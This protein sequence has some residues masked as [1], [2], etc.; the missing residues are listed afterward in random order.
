MTEH[1]D[2]HI[3]K[4][5]TTILLVDDDP[6]ILDG[7]TDLLNIY[8]YQVIAVENGHRALEVM[9]STPPN[10]VIS[11]ISMP[12]MDGYALF[13]A[14]RSNPE[15]VPIPFIF[16]T[17]RGQLTDIRRGRRIGA[18]GYLTKPFDPEELLSAVQGQIKR[19]QDIRVATYTDVEAMKQRLIAVFSH[20]L[21]T[22]LT[23]IY[24]YVNLLRD[25]YPE[26]GQD[27]IDEMLNG[28]QA[29]AERLYRLV[30]DLML[31]VRIDSGVVEVEIALGQ[32]NLPL[33]KIIEDISYEFGHKAKQRNVTLAY[34]VPEELKRMPVSLYIRDALKRLIDNAIKF[35][36]QEGGSV[37]VT[38]SH[39]DGKL[40]IAVSDD[41][42]G[43][44]PVQQ[45]IIFE[46]FQQA[47][48]DTLEQQGLGL[49]LTLARALV[50]LHS[51]EIALESQTGIGSTF[52]LI[53]PTDRMNSLQ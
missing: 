36:K 24:G 19:T 9:Q 26:L 20:E 17:A 22:P 49:G 29:G 43:I 31:M 51:G 27:A 8:G 50:R 3:A 14:V 38:L 11:D 30:E 41:G 33:G 7:V 42:I 47:N 4:M 32:V 18:D 16:L 15:W 35:S 37:D 6:A 2:D 48:R 40:T 46:S 25:Q 39:A 1:G 34:H 5:N 45:D 28:I 53:L 52:T 10:L 13:E 44:E 12:S 23:Y 21:R